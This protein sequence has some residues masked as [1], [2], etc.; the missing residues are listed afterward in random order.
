[1]ESIV[2]VNRERVS[3]EHDYLLDR[4]LDLSLGLESLRE[5]YVTARRGRRLSR[6]L[7]GDPRFRRF[8][9]VVILASVTLEEEARVRGVN[10]TE[11]AK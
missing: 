1:M 9:G 4:L 7:R 6:C 5:L 11:L 3:L 8:T 2:S 10:F